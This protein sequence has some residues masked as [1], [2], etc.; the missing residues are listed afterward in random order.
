MRTG[1]ISI[2][3]FV[4]HFANATIVD[5]PP[6]GHLP[7][8][9]LNQ[10][11]E[12][13]YARG[14]IPNA[15]PSS[16]CG[17]ASAINWL[18]LEYGP[19][20]KDRQIQLLQLAAQLSLQQGVD[21]HNGLIEPQ[22]IQ[23]MRNLDTLLVKEHTYQGKGRYFS[24]NE[25]TTEDLFSSKRQ[26]LLLRYDSRPTA[27]PS[28]GRR[29]RGPRG[30]QD[31]M[32]PIVNENEIRGFHF[33][34]KVAALPET[35]EIVFLDPENPARYS[36]AKLEI[37]NNPRNQKPELRLLPSSRQDLASFSGSGLMLWTALSS[38]EKHKG[39]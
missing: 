13:L 23:Y 28:M 16:L 25:L 38:I 15:G 35:R 27:P 1:L 12:E 24:D 29:D 10:N 32:I 34:L 22:L 20:S 7:S 4:F 26:I 30:G 3:F 17:P 2:L 5:L 18:Q 39:E 6:E 33:V 21:V 19:F 14:I 11:D 36:R 9:M 37:R 8:L 31:P